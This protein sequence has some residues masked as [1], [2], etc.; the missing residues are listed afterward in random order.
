MAFLIAAVAVSVI[1]GVAGWLHLRKTR[2]QILREKSN[3]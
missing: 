2:K 3:V 1:Y